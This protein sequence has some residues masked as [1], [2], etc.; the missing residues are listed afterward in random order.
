[1]A[2]HKSRSGNRGGKDLGDAG[3]IASATGGQR[4]GQQ[5]RL[6][7]PQQGDHTVLEQRGRTDSAGGESCCAPTDSSATGVAAAAEAFRPQGQGNG[8]GKATDSSATGVAAAAE[9]FRPQGQGNGR[10]KAG[11]YEPQGVAGA[12]GSSQPW[13]CCP[14]KARA[15]S[16]GAP[17]SAEDCATQAVDSANRGGAPVSA[18]DSAT[19]AAETFNETAAWPVVT[20]AGAGPWI[21]IPQATVVAAASAA[22]FTAARLGASPAV[23]ASEVAAAIHE[24]RHWMQPH[25]AAAPAVQVEADRV[26]AWW[27]DDLSPH[28]DSKE[29]ERSEKAIEE[30]ELQN[31][32]AETER[33]DK[34]R[35]ELKAHLSADSQISSASTV[36]TEADL[37]MPA[38]DQKS[39]VFDGQSSGTS[40]AGSEDKSAQPA[41]EALEAAE[42]PRPP[43]KTG[44]GPRRTQA[45]ADYISELGYD[46]SDF[47]DIREG[48]KDHWRQSWGLAI[49]S[50]C[51]LDCVRID[52][53]VA[54]A[55]RFRC[56]DCDAEYFFDHVEG[57]KQTE[58]GY[59]G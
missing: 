14:S 43:E 41:L 49:C 51:D 54:E 32:F 50:V 45:L 30:D 38:Y 3:S 35:R 20:G 23:I 18:E 29:L 42:L 5:H 7:L 8:Q 37:T 48:I 27:H 44:D 11:H 4:V 9:A 2:R 40:E 19:Q 47:D 6:Q 34:P 22:A 36:A 55:S 17:V 56:P 16:G 21:P 33:A 52:D 26:Q 10:G 25:L 31:G 59:F 58:A 57:D 39:G 28:S 15:H 1:M 53:G 12:P 24:M 46:D 13:S